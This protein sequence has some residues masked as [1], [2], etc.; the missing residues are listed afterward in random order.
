MFHFICVLNYYTLLTFSICAVLSNYHAGRNRHKTEQSS[1]SSLTNIFYIFYL[2][3]ILSK[4]KQ[5]IPVFQMDPN[6]IVLDSDDEDEPVVVT[7]IFAVFPNSFVYLNVYYSYF[8]NNFIVKSPVI[9]K[10]GTKRP[11]VK[12]ETEN[13]KSKCPKIEEPSSKRRI[14]PLKIGEATK[15]SKIIPFGN[16]NEEEDES[17]LVLQE[18]KSKFNE[19]NTDSKMIMNGDSAASS[20]SK[21]FLNVIDPNFQKFINACKKI[22]NSKD[23]DKIVEKK[24]LKYY[25]AVHPDFINSKVFQKILKKSIEDIKETPNDVYVKLKI[26]IEELDIRRK[27]NV[28]V[29]ANEEVAVKGTGDEKKDEHLN[30]L[31]K[32]LLLLKKRILKLEHEDVD[33]D[34]NELDSSYVMKE[35]FE[36]RACQVRTILINS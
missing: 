16:E 32:S 35:K 12:D 14:T 10:A 15:D 18:D 13:H 3:K 23:M 36:K 7:F 30:K 17:L 20:S 24:L 9:T 11:L 1:F 8:Q 5:N 22:D 2:R 28:T 21:A 27:S 31:Y 33:F 34:A 29:V 6:I 19:D 25:H 26:V 4:V